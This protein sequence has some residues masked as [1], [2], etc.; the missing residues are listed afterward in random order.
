MLISNKHFRTGFFLFLGLVQAHR[1]TTE[2]PQQIPKV[3]R[4]SAKLPPKFMA[5]KYGFAEGDKVDVSKANKIHEEAE[6]LGERA[7][8]FF[9]VTEDEV[10]L[11]PEIF[12]T[13][14]MEKVKRDFAKEGDSADELELRNSRWW[15]RLYIDGW[16]QTVQYL[17]AH[18]GE[19]PPMGERKIMIA[20]PIDACNALDGDYAG[21]IVMARR[22][23]CTFSAKARI[24][25]RAKVAALILVNNEEGNDHLAGPDAHDVG[26][27]VSMVAMVDGELVLGALEKR[28]AESGPLTG[29]M[30]PIHCAERTEALAGALGSDLCAPTTA[31]DRAFA[32]SPMEGGRFSL[33]GA[34]AS[35]EF[36]IATFGVVV[37]RGLK[38]DLVLSDP[39]NG[40][41]RLVGGGDLT[42]EEFMDVKNN[43][44]TA[45]QMAAA[46]NSQYKG[47]VVVVRRGGCSFIDKAK[48]LQAAGAAMIVVVNSE[49]S[50]SRFGV[51]P[52]WKGLVIDI[53]VVMVTDVGGDVL[54][55]S[56]NQKISFELSRQV[57]AKTWE[58]IAQVRSGDLKSSDLDKDAQSDIWPDRVAALGGTNAKS[59]L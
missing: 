50:L 4:D 52:R 15:G 11:L 35:H 22:G 37:D 29:A 56:M 33:S 1:F 45:D 44:A 54:M 39:Q 16:P 42:F 48:T 55:G 2:D 20:N 36:M 47:K 21:A 14:D 24:A 19:A 58:S 49:T 13:L 26:I 53:P 41:E 5:E 7:P 30:I 6:K 28:S 34:S 40:C 18:F 8:N 51:E 38:Y 12:S 32:K 17:R 57:D 3:H 25:A 9:K 27:S 23:V 43:N 10:L 59:D 31:N 46:A